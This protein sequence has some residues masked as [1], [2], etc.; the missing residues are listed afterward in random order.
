LG[1]RKAPQNTVPYYNTATGLQNQVEPAGKMV[2]A[3][4]ECKAA[5]CCA[6]R[7]LWKR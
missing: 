3:I 6:G 5:A 4:K 2:Y 7:M 1:H